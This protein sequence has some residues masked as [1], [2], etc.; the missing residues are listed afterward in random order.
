MKRRAGRSTQSLRT[1]RSFCKSMLADVRALRRQAEKLRAQR[2]SERAR[3][4]RRM[5][6]TS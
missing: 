4:A 6:S 2:S 1:L 3:K 5:D